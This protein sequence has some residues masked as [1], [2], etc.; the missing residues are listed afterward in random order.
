MTMNRE[1]RLAYTLSLSLAALII[2][3][4]IVPRTALA[5]LGLGSLVVT[6]TAPSNG[7]HVT[8]TIPVRASVTS[9]GG[10]TVQSVQFKLD[11]ANLGAADTSQPYAISWDT[12]TASNASHTLTAVARDAFGVDWTSNPVTVT[13]FNDTTPPS[14]SVTSPA[15]S[16]TVSGTITMTANASD[17]VG[18]VGVQFQ[19]DGVNAGA[20]ATSAP[21]SAPWNT[22]SAANGSHVVTAVAR[23]AA[24]NRG[25]SA[26]VTVSVFNDTIAPSVSITSPAAG[27]TVSGRVNVTAGASDNVGVVGVQ[28]KLDGANLGTEVTAAP[29]AASWDTASATNASHVL[30]AVA[31]DAAGN[32][33]TSAAVSV[34]VANLSPV[35]IENQQPGSGNWAMWMGGMPA[36]D[37][38]KQIKGYA[39][40]TSVN[41]G[42]SITFYVSAAPVQTYTIDIYRMGYYQGLGGRLLQSVGPLQAVQQPLCPADLNTGLIECNWSASYTLAVPA[43]WTSGIFLAKLTSAAGFQNW[44]TFVVRDDARTAGLLYAQPVN[45]YQAY[46]NYPNDNATGKSIYN[47]N[48]FGAPTLS[49][50]ARAVKVSWNRPYADR[51]AGQFFNWESYF[52]RWIERS[53]YDVKYVTSVDTHQ[54]SDRLLGSKGFLSIAHDEYYSKEMYDGLETARAGGVHLAFFGANGVYWQV[55]FEPSPLTGVADRVMV[56]YKDRTTDPVQGPTTTVQFRDPFINRPEQT[57]MGVQFNGQIAFDAPRAPF[58]VKNSS[59][60]V[61]TGTG[62]RDGDQIPGIVGYEMDGSTASAPLPDAIGSTYEILSESPYTDSGGAPQ[63][64]NA[65]IYQ[66]PSGAWVFGAGATDW[67]WGL[68]LDGTVDP[69][70]QRITSNILDRFVGKTP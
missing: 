41:K 2:L 19:V 47:F 33:A 44:I 4:S 36:D 15:A 61:Y 54:H 65:T 37:V 59:S 9:I 17:N 63:V 22:L 57:L 68:D 11:G 43:D 1:Q 21:Y 34:T 55:R 50:T 58:V 46:N 45:T 38:N 60:W 42:D 20:E 14:V 69:R 32:L 10:L 3:G 7:A 25:T 27:A 13:V 30:T 18:V 56:G 16:A 64:S 52:V 40:A 49:G 62:V 5:Q 48:S 12:R 6:V 26:A 29:Y 8:G 39:S 24:G 51:G 28:F 53:G 66:A 23:D 70:I 35:A 31:R 67:A